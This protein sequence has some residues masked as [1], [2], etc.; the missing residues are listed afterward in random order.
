VLSDDAYAVLAPLIGLV[1]GG[2]SSHEATRLLRS[3]GFLRG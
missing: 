3:D 2:P 1:E